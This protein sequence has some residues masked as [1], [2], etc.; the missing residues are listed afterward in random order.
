LTDKFETENDLMNSGYIGQTVGYAYS[1]ELQIPEDYER[2]GEYKT[3][4]ER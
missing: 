2:Y 1:D 4:M 3:Y